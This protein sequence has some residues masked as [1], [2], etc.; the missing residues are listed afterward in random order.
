MSLAKWTLLITFIPLLLTF[1]YAIRYFAKLGRELQ[2]FSYFIFFSTLVQ[3]ISLFF[4][5]NG[6]NNMPLL[7][8]YVPLGFMGIAWFYA[9]L[10]KGFLHPRVLWGLALLF[11]IF[12]GI[13]SWVIQN[14]YTFNTYALTVESVLVVILSLSTFTLHLNQWV[15]SRKQ[16]VL[17][18]LDWINSGLFIYY[19]SNLLFFYFGD[20]LTRFSPEIRRLSWFPHSFF[21]I[22]MYSCFFVGLWKYPKT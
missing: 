9:T 19:A 16:R 20:A 5:S 18:S 21:S 4:W 1:G 3:L 17:T 7:H 6:W 15:K 12:S 13:N 14:V 22:V 8:F 10:L 2:V 11:L